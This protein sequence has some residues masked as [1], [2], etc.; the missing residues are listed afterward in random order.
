MQRNIQEA[1]HVAWIQKISDSVPRNW[2]F[3]FVQVSG[4][5]TRSHL[6]LGIY[7]PQQQNYMKRNLQEALHVAWIQKISDPI[8]MSRVFFGL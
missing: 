6:K 7:T 4:F 2:V 3:F 5:L 1:L 8:R